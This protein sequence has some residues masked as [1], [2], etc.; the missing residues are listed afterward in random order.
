M[1]ISDMSISDMKI[2]DMKISEMD[3]TLRAELL[4]FTRSVNFVYAKTMP[5]CPHFYIVRKKVDEEGYVKLW[6]AIEQ[7]GEQEKYQNCPQG[8]LYLG[9]GW[10]YWKMCSDI[11]QSVIINRARGVPN[12]EL[13]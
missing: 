1:S 8:Y 7:Y 6:N 13:S 9:D 5:Q 10:K 3:E 2:L 4:A 12:G 11:K